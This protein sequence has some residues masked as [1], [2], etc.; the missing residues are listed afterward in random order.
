MKKEKEI[1]GHFE[2][3]PVYSS[4]EP[5]EGFIEYS[6]MVYSYLNTMLLNE[7]IYQ[8]RFNFNDD[9]V[10]ITRKEDRFEIEKV[11]YITIV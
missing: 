6:D 1:Q 4:Y 8:L 9:E 7:N 11:Y 10:S 5:T 3:I 2:G